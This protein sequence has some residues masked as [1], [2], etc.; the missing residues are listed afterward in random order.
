MLGSVPL[1]IWY[2]ASTLPPFAFTCLVI[3][4]FTTLM[5]A[6]T[7]ALYTLIVFPRPSYA[8][9]SVLLNCRYTAPRL[10]FGFPPPCKA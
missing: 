3:N 2:G 9:F 5:F 1:V 7:K 6:C 10:T 8:F 4:T